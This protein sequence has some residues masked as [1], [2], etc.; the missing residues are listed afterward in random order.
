MNQSPIAPPTVRDYLRILARRWWV[1]VLGVVLFTLLLVAYSYRGPTIYK[2]TSEVR[3]TSGDSSSV[4]V[5]SGNRSSAGSASQEV[6]TE[7]EVL[8]SPNFKARIT[9]QLN[10]GA[11]AIKQV[12]VSNVLSTNAIKISVGMPTANQAVEVAD[13]YA[14]A[15]VREVTAQ[16]ALLTK[17]RTASTAT[18]LASVKQQV[19]RLTADINTEARRVDAQDASLASRNLPT[20]RGSALLTSLQAQLNQT[21]PGYTALQQQYFQIL[22]ANA[23]AQPTVSRIADAQKPST[24]SQPTPIKYGIVGGFLGIIFG[25][26]GAFVFELLT[27]RVRSRQDVE[28]F[29]R[30]PVLATVP[31]RGQRRGSNRPVALA[32]PSS[33]VA[34]AYRAARSGVQF[35][36]M[37][38]PMHRILVTGLRAKDH[39]DV[40]AANLAVT[41]AAAGSRV[42]VVDAD[43][44]GGQLHE[45]F[46][47]T[48]GTGLTSILLGDASLADS[49][50]PVEVPGG[51]L[52]VLSTGPLPPNPADLVASESLAAVLSQLADGADYVVVSAPALLPYNDALAAAR[53]VDGVIMVATARRTRR[54]DLADGAAKL[55]RVG[56]PAVGIV[57]DRG[58]R[59]ADAYE[60]SVGRVAPPE[61]VTTGAGSA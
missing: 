2:A 58:S 12:N 51:A 44:R 22:S 54:R 9:K 48:R 25:I 52:R 50:R 26:V 23:A 43:L 38:A 47:L 8:K 46:G 34:E 39:Q 55:R 17:E 21:L 20:L 61:P 14:A 4:A 42:V 11:K 28:R 31:R 13:A 32:N 19:D 7:V 37:R 36:S 59:G 41:L 57:L 5:N 56:A 60:A 24:P 18:Q 40:A 33:P 45:R 29:S 27:D 15:Y 6:L 35:L 30:L 10:L 1:V 53:H 16:Q 49:L 3:F